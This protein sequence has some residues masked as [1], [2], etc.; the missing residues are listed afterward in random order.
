[1]K[2]IILASSSASRKTVLEKLGLPFLAVS[3]DVDETPLLNESAENLVIRLAQA[4]A[5]ALSQHYPQ[6]LIIG[7]DQVCVIE[8]KILGKPLTFENAVLQLKQASGKKITFYTSVCL[9]D[10]ATGSCQVQCEP[11]HVHFRSLNDEEIVTYLRKDEPYYCAGSFKSEGLGITLF[12]KLEGRDPNTLIGLP[13][14][15]LSQML[16]NCGVNPLQR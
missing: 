6:H 10:S 9:L 7:S 8:D 11:F 13:L 12:D 14:I 4:K 5:H 3:P 2:S 1:M 15:L 16:R